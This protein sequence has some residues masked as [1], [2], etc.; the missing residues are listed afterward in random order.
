MMLL[1]KQTTFI[2]EKMQLISVGG[3]DICIKTEYFIL[4]SLYASEVYISP[5]VII[6]CENE[7]T[8]FRATS[9]VCGSGGREQHILS[10]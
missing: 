4:T 10:M 6:L 3:S 9:V 1:E 5:E 2:L 7:S 8:V